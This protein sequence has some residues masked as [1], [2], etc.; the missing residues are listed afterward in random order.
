[1]AWTKAVMKNS[2]RHLEERNSILLFLGP[3]EYA[4]A[5]PSRS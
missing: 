4:G 2:R 5:M 3:D 1:M